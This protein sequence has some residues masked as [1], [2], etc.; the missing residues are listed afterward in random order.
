LAPLV[1]LAASLL[2]VAFHKMALAARARVKKSRSL[3]DWLRPVIGGLITWVLGV[4]AYLGTGR[5]GIF[6]LGYKDLS[7]VLNNN[8]LFWIAGIMVVGK[9]LATVA[10]Y[11]FGGCGGIFSPLLFIGGLTGFFL[12]GL[13]S[14]WLPLT[15]SDLIVLSAVGMSCCLG[16]VVKAPLSAMLIVFEMTHQFAIVPA[17]LIGM[18][19]SMAVSRLTGS[20]NFYDAILVQDGHEI[21]KIRPP[22]DVQGWRSQ[23]VLAIASPRPVVIRSRDAASLRAVLESHPYACFPWAPEG[24]ALAVVTREA[25]E[26]AL[27]KGRKPRLETAITCTAENTIAEAAE[28]FIDT[29]LGFL[30]VTDAEGGSVVAILTLHDLLRAQAAVSD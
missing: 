20:E 21:H 7:S 3:P 28:R 26:E 2:G 9:L 22:L 23:G 11:G 30:V 25:L 5:L 10:S 27:K 19:V 13:F 16:T 6:S 12:G 24:E 18:V 15:P 8:Y 4:A 1:A 29:H 14:T 17:L